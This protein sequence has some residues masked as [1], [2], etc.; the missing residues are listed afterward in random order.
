MESRLAL[1]DLT[2]AAGEI[3]VEARRAQ[4]RAEQLKLSY[5]TL[6]TLS[7][8]S[9]NSRRAL[10]S[11]EIDK[12][13]DRIAQLVEDAK[14]FDDGAPSLWQATIDDILRVQM[15]LSNSIKE[16]RGLREELDREH[17]QIESQCAKRRES[18]DRTRLAR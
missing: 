13:T 9:G 10:Y 17:D 18:M 4:S 12:K 7:G 3:Q 11:A 6:F 1:R 15:R 8:S 14:K 2:L 5:G 16:V